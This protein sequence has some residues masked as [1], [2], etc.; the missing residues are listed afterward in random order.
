MENVD[1]AL[2]AVFRKRAVSVSSKKQK[3]G[4]VLVLLL[5][6][7]NVKFFACIFQLIQLQ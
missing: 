3:K 4:N 5:G 2:S 7:E 6:Y 1:K